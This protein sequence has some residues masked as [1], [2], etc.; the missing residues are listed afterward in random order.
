MTERDLERRPVPVPAAGPAHPAHPARPARPVI[1]DPRTAAGR[2]WRRLRAH[3]RTKLWLGALLAALFCAGYFAIE[4]HP[5][6][7]ATALRLTAID[8]AVPFAPR[9][10]WVYQSIYLLLPLA[11][12]CETA[13]QLRRYALGF[14]GLSAVGFACFLCWPIAGPRPLELPADPL[15]RLLVSYDSPANCL[16]S[17]HVA[18]AAYA[19]AVAI[20]VTGGAGRRLLIAVLPA[21]VALIAYSTLATKQHYW[22]DLPPGILLGWLAQRLAFRSYGNHGNQGNQGNQGNADREGPHASP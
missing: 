10:V 20:A 5:L 3:W 4:R 8:R 6:R 19:A 7:P 9:W 15:Y 18:L 1:D 14:L 2:P 12:L 11:W 22:V 13:G 17:L 16:P 21:W